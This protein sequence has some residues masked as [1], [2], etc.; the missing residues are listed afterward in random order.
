[1]KNLY[2]V[3]V[4]KEMLKNEVICLKFINLSKSNS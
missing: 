2:F 1:M 3:M 4:E